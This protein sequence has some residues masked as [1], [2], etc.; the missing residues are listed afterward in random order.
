MR[1]VEYKQKQGA[2]PFAPPSGDE[3]FYAK[4]TIDSLYNQVGGLKEMLG[5][6]QDFALK[7]EDAIWQLLQ[8]KSDLD[9]WM[10]NWPKVING[11][12]VRK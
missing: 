4:A 12:T 11:C 9:L 2:M 5:V 6:A 7:A 8:E 1:V 10:Q 3:C